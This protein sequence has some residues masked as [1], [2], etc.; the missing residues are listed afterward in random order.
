MPLP[1]TIAEPYE[2]DA[3]VLLP[4]SDPLP[5]SP[6]AQVSALAS[7]LEE[8]LSGNDAPPLV[9]IT[10]SMRT[11][12]RNA[13]S[14]QN[15]SRLGA[16]QARVQLNEAD[17]GLQTAE[18]ELARVREEMAVCRAYE[19]MYETIPMQSETD[20]IASASLTTAS[21]DD[22]MARKYGILLARLEAELGFVQAQEKRIAELTAQRDELVRSRR[23]I[24]K[25]A[26]AVDVL[27]ADYSKVSHTML[28]RRS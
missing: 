28:K 5:A 4:V 10:G 12:Q 11:A 18:Y 23:E 16:A 13:Q 20:F 22:P 21:D 8:H 17:V 27:L 2:H 6:A 1:K 24:A 3:L 7:A 14:M 9:P 19:P 15:A 26:D 25:K